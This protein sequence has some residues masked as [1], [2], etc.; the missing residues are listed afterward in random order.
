MIHHL[1]VYAPGGVFLFH[2][3]QTRNMKSCITIS[4][5]LTL[6][7]ILY[8]QP[9]ITRDNLVVPGDELHVGIVD[10]APAPG[11]GGANVIWNFSSIEPS[12]VATLDV[13]DADDTPF[14]DDFPGA[15][16]A[17]VDNTPNAQTFQYLSITNSAW[18]EHGSFFP[19]SLRIT[20][21]NPRT[22]LQFPVMYNGQWSDD[23]TYT[24]S[25]ETIPPI[26][27]FGEGNYDTRV[28]GYG[29]LILPEATFNDVLRVRILGES[30]DTTDLGAGLYERNY[31]HDTTYLWLSPSYN[32]PLCAYTGSLIMRTTTVI[33]SD[34]MTFPET[35]TFKAFSFDPDAEPSSVTEHIQPGLYDMRISPNP[36]EELLQMKFIAVQD[37]EMVFVLRDL[38][39]NTVCEQSILAQAQENK[40]EIPLG[41]LPSGTFIAMLY[42]EQ[43]I[44]IQKVIHVR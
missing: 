24:I 23:Y 29:T 14:A 27:T 36:F 9:I 16:I 39:G 44:D 28:D 11:P 33:S 15:N 5:L 37:Q 6:S 3:T 8:A 21:E 12:S 42:S 17:F 19:G 26:S 30:T 41:D 22:V 43:G 31:F 7:S 4:C 38:H 34:T 35:I 20:Y 13:E 25:Y 18:E 10:A 40:V 2:T 32:A 1:V